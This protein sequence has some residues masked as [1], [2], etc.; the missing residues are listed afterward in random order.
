MKNYIEKTRKIVGD[1]QALIPKKRECPQ[2]IP[3]K[4]KF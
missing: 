2:K 4:E 1:R 3:G